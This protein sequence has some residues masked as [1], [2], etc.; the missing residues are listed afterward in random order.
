M[1]EQKIRTGEKPVRINA[2]QA[3]PLAEYHRPRIHDLGRLEQVQGYY[4][5]S[6]YDGP[7]PRWLRY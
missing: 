1:S 3:G 2:E 6:Y 7:V 4:T 5:G